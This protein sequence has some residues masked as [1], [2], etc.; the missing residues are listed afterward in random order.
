MR[1][2]R[3]EFV[4]LAS[5]AAL[6]GLTACASA[7]E[8][9]NTGTNADASNKDEDKEKV[10]L[11]EFESLAID[12]TAWKYDKA[13]DV[14]YQ[15]GLPYCLKPGSGSCETLAIF[16]PGAYFVAKEHG[17]TYACTINTSAKVGGFTA[18]TAPVAMPINSGT[19]SPQSSPTS[20]GY[21]GLSN[22]LDAGF[23]YVYAGF[24]GRSS[25]FESGSNDV[26]SGGAPWP[27]VDLKAAVR[28]L[29]YNA[30]V[31]PIDPA[32]IFTFGFSMGGGV[33]S[34]MGTSGDSELYAPYLEAIGAV[35]HDAEGNVISD[36]TF[37]S[38]SWC[39]ITSFDTADASY[40]WMM[41]Q[42]ENDNTRAEGTWTKTMSLDLARAYG[43]YINEMDLRDE[44]DQ[45]L[46]LD[47]TSAEMYADGSYY[48]QV[49][50]C[51]EASAQSFFERT[52]FPYTH[53]PNHVTN[54]SFPGDANLLSAG[55]GT[56]DVE[57]V[58]SDASAQAATGV[59]KDEVSNGGKTRIESVVYATQEDYINELN[60]NSWW[61]T[62]NQRSGAVRISS[63]ADFVNRLK[64]A[65]KDVC[66]FDGIDRSTVENQLFGIDE[67]GCLH[68]SQMVCDQ[69]V[70]HR[71][72]YAKMD[73][74]DDSL[75]REWTGD[76]IELDSL[77]TDMITRMR[78]FNPLYYVSG[79]Y[80]GYGT[81]AVAPHWRINS[82]IFQTDT[83]LCTELNLSL[84][85]KHY[86]GV[87]DVAFTPVW[88]QGHELAEESGTA[89]EN[90]VAWMIA[91]CEAK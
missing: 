18:S 72:D 8:E 20:Y 43:V 5:G 60:N 74:W 50:K 81:A 4:S 17:K 55:A 25:G 42:Y 52:K 47:E 86:D 75:V 33:S 31:L 53:T 67:A 21:T 79:T 9:Q 13:H 10:D 27:V 23:V 16:V 68:F 1:C 73:D 6:A 84:A 39:P 26:F 82:G 83:A 88:G 69:L 45:E 36:K 30:S 2:S 65:A 90:L 61:L 7:G 22:Y 49:L 66:A 78:M 41:G 87:A 58:T 19:L 76:L 77:E 35:M 89:E 57:V 54:A 56:S 91:C 85:L 28:F 12:V 32:R 71:D 64:R 37:G 51:I 46:T 44:A 62:Y 14:F 3:R 29:R 24:R 48:E 15:L 38:A 80:D 63:I 59:Q 40:E 34:L 11:N 70:E